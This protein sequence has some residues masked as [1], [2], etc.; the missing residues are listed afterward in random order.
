MSWC[1]NMQVIAYV[2]YLQHLKPIK[3]HSI[4]I[5]WFS[6]IDKIY[7]KVVN[8]SVCLFRVKRP[9][10]KMAWKD[11]LESSVK[12][13]S[14]NVSGSKDIRI[15]RKENIIKKFILY[16]SNHYF[17]KPTFLS[18]PRLLYLL[19]HFNTII[20]IFIPCHSLKYWSFS[21]EPNR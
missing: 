13:V 7:V 2:E 16:H 4:E 17:C 1:V 9:C 8:S 21:R 14:V 19:F 20:Y 12:T 10:W 6:C 15:H 3:V 18:L 5:W 11:N